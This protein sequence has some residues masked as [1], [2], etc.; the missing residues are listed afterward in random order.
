MAVCFWKTQPPRS[1][2]APKELIAAVIEM[3]RRNPHFGCRNIAEQI[4][5]TF[6][7]PIDKDVVRRIWRSTIGQ[8]PM[9]MAFPG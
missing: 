5:H 6:G 1:Q 9:A 3:K 2:G 7:I 8:S 4:A